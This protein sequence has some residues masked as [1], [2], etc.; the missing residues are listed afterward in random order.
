MVSFPR[1]VDF[2]TLYTK[3]PLR[4]IMLNMEDAID[5]ALDALYAEL[6]P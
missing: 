1:T 5:E 6:K 4:D 3:L 2:T